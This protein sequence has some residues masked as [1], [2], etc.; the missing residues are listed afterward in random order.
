MHPESR[1]ITAL[2]H[3][4]PVERSVRGNM[5]ISEPSATLSYVTWNRTNFPVPNG[6]TNLKVIAAIIA[7]KKLLE[8]SERYN[9]PSCFANL[10]HITLG[11][12]KYDTSSRLNKTPPMGAPNA[13]A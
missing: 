12:K 9:W 10:L 6:S 11:G 5:C 13:T 4:S 2:A 1:K 8:G 3:A 7:Q